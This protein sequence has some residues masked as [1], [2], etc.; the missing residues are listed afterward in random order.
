MSSSPTRRGRGPLLFLT[1]CV[2]VFALVAGWLRFFGGGDAP[3]GVTLTDLRG[4]DDLKARFNA[5]SGR[6]RLVVIFSP[7]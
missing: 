2:A 1:V 4:V 6:T 3:P 5:D 7:T